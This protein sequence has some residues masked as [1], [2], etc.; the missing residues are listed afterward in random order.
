MLRPSA[1]DGGAIMKIVVIG[2]ARS[3]TPSPAIMFYAVAQR[4]Q[5]RMA[6]L[7]DPYR[8]ECHYMRGPGPK[9]R[10]KHSLPEH[11]LQ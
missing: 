10:E 2:A 9:C 6:C 11:G 1:L 3:G 7:F 4:W 5:K 8:P